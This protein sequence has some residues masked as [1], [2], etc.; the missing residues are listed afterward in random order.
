MPDRVVRLLP[1]PPLLQKDFYFRRQKCVGES[2]RRWFLGL[3]CLRF[4]S[5][6]DTGSTD[7]LTRQYKQLKVRFLKLQT[8]GRRQSRPER[9][10]KRTNGYELRRTH[11]LWSV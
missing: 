7:S 5:F 9:G 6:S 3:F 8:R 4:H 1:C 10:Y 2:Q 11:T